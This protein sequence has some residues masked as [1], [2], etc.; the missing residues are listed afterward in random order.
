MLGQ[1]FSQQRLLGEIFGA[2]D[3]GIDLSAASGEEKAQR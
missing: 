1:N 2:H 3:D